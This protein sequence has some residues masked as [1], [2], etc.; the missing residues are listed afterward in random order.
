MSKTRGLAHFAIDRPNAFGGITYSTAC[1]KIHAKPN[2]L[3]QYDAALVKCKN[4]LKALSNT[5]PGSFRAQ[6][7][8]HYKKSVA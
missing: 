1:G 6:I 2:I 4:C 5:H 8:A 7:L 3:L